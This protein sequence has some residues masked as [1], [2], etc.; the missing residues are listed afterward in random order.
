MKCNILN[1]K[2]ASP[3]IFKCNFDFPHSANA[4]TPWNVQSTTR[5]ECALVGS[6]VPCA[7]TSVATSVARSAAAAGTRRGRL[8]VDEM[9]K[10]AIIAGKDAGGRERQGTA[11]AEVV[12]RLREER[13][14][15]GR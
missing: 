1:D 11:G 10:V 2:G 4:V 12:G 6:R 8:I 9:R 14:E 13:R 5:Q 3:W 7:T 15:D